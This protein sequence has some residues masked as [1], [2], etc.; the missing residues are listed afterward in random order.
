[1]LKQTVR[2]GLTNFSQVPQKHHANF[3][4]LTDWQKFDMLN[5]Y[6]QNIKTELSI[7]TTFT[8]TKHLVYSIYVE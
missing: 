6:T 2:T 8:A 1:M 4:E 5:T 3:L 7:L